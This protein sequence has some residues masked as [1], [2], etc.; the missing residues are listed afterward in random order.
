MAEY[1][2]VMLA[3]YVFRRSLRVLCCVDFLPSLSVCV[4]VSVNASNLSER[5]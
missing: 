1:A 3:E 2:Q 5:I 4:S